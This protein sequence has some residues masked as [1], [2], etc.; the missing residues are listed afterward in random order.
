MRTIT[1]VGC[2]LAAVALTCHQLGVEPGGLEW[3][4]GAGVIVH[5]RDRAG[6]DK[7][8]EH[9][10]APPGR[11]RVDELQARR[12]RPPGCVHGPARGRVVNTATAKRGRSYVQG[13][14]AEQR[15]VDSAEIRVRSAVEMIAWAA[16]RGMVSK[17]V[18][19]P[20]P[21]TAC[22]GDPVGTLRWAL[23][24]ARQAVETRRI[25]VRDVVDA[26]ERLPADRAQGILESHLA[27][28]DRWAGHSTEDV[29]WSIQEL[30]GHLSTDLA[31]AQTP[32]FVRDLILDQTLG[33]GRY[34]DVG[35]WSEHA[36]DG[37]APRC[38]DPACGTGLFLTDIYARLRR[39][40]PDRPPA[41][42]A[43]HCAG[44]DID[45]TLA[46]LARFRLAAAVW[47]D[48]GRVPDAV[49]PVAWGDSL[50]CWA[51]PLQ[52]WSV[53][54]R[55]DGAQHAEL[56]RLLLPCHLSGA[57]KRCPDCGPNQEQLAM[58]DSA[59]DVAS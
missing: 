29:A 3:I 36:S 5:C 37:A 19:P 56:H 7:L 41:E 34:P 27:A 20:T 52:P 43:Q 45:E 22:Q 35:W 9:F 8:A 18:L 31:F 44:C 25:V 38:I 42:L 28:P 51:S 54:R 57:G 47:E 4:D 58:W 32:S 6:V 33:A 24:C 39:L 23:W 17:W 53:Q 21:A 11:R 40:F 16:S 49:P 10:R 2:E 48:T 12:V 14:T 55:P 1:E 13:T 30:G 46:G 15:R 26:L 50:L 59:P